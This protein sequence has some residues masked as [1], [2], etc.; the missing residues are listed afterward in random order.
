LGECAAN[1]AEF[2]A[3]KGWFVRLK[4]T[5]ATV[6]N[7]RTIGESASANEQAALEFVKKY[8]EIVEG[9]G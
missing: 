2:R 5:R 8:A 3:S 4:S 6:Y 9:A 7:I 1:A